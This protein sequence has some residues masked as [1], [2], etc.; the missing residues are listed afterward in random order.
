MKPR[1]TRINPDWVGKSLSRSG[2]LQSAAK[3]GAPRQSPLTCSAD[4]YFQPEHYFE[5]IKPCLSNYY[6]A[7]KSRRRADKTK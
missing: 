7:R 2:G 6:G 1:I 4:V 5:R 3:L